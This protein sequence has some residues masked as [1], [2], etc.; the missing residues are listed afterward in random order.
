[1]TSVLVILALWLVLGIF[2]LRRLELKQQ[3]FWLCVGVLFGALIIRF[4]CLDHQTSDYQNAF[5]PWVQH[6]RDNGGFAGIRDRVGDYN[7]P[8]LYFLAALSYL[9]VNDL[10]YIKL[11]SIFCDLLLALVALRLV[12]RLCP[13]R[14]GAWAGVFCAVLLLPTVVLNSSY[15]GQCDGLYA[16]LT[17][18]ALSDALESHPARSVVWLGIAF[19]FK[20]QTIFLIPLWCV[21]WYSKR[22]KFKQ[23]WLFPLAYFGTILP[24]L[25]LGKPLKDILMIYVNQTGAYNDR[26]TLNA[27][28]I[29]A[30]IPS[31]AEVD[32][33]LLAA[34]GVWAA[35][36][37]VLG[38]L[39]WL[40]FRREKLDDHAL[41]TAGLFLAI[42]IPLLL[43][44]MHDRYFFL[45]D[46]LAVI[47][48]AVDIRRLPVPAAVQIASLGGY[49]AYLMLRYA[50]PMAWG[51]WM[52]IFALVWTGVA[53]V[54]WDQTAKPLP[55]SPSPAKK[56]AQAKP[57]SK[58]GKKR[59][60]GKK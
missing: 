2:L 34:L 19:S 3:W 9:P 35:F 60:S 41:V 59:R 5:A 33:K 12:R 1:M 10:Y 20:L 15:W 51:T 27:P 42:G 43:P 13:E 52:V 7:V 37:L 49:H 48:C 11:L 44:H 28:S 24:A 31:G 23:L 54:R 21:L 17:L 4:F 22:V 53:L 50:F 8:Y 36:L 56:P 38:L 47:W 40:F 55:A 6:F 25:L 39:G 26:L 46:L 57:Q 58:A 32:D 14:Q 29:Y 16:A 45:A 18:L 30:L